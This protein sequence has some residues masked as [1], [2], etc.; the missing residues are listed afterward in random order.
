M[1]RLAL[2]TCTSRWINPCGGARPLSY[3]KGKTLLRHARPATDKLLTAAP[4][5]QQQQNPAEESR[6]RSVQQRLDA[7]FPRHYLL[8]FARRVFA[9][10][11]NDKHQFWSTLS[12]KSWPGSCLVSC[13]QTLAKNSRFVCKL[14][15][16]STKLAQTNSQI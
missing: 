10:R 3:F 14:S 15:S 1:F 2:R 8:L 5:Q 16:T 7:K 9:K 11:K 6:S 4:Q 12:F 13:L